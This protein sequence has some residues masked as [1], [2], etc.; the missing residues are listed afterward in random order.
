[1]T[2]APYTP[3]MFLR[4]LDLVTPKKEPAKDY[5]AYIGSHR[6]SARGS[7]FSPQAEN[8]LKSAALSRPNSNATNEVYNVG[9]EVIHTSF[10]VGKVKELLPGNKILVEFPS[11]YG[12]KKLMIG[13]KAFRK[14]REGE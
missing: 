8:I 6:P 12:E 9:D 13:F 3:S 5:S 7:L 14:K 11:P 4:E 10:G 2:G 1:M